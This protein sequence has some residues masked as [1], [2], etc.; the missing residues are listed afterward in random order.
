MVR[1]FELLRSV[2]HGFVFVNLNDFDSKYGHRRDV[3]GYA[4]A[5]ERLDRHV[6]QL[7][8]ALRPGDVAIFTADHGC[9]P[10]A[11][12]SDHTREY[13]P[14]LELG[15]RRGIGSAS[16]ALDAVGRRIAEV[17]TGYPVIAQTTSPV[18]P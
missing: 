17:L 6:P 14:Y 13:V 15:L 8:A 12:G 1:T 10:T 16:P 7:E 9:D 5:L 2:E 4:A 11:P 3:R 18:A